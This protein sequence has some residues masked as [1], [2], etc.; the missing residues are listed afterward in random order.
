MLDLTATVHDICILIKV[1]IT[2]SQVFINV[3]FSKY[4]QA[5]VTAHIGSWKIQQLNGTAWKSTGGRIG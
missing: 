5:R 3:Y 4:S 2:S 1:V